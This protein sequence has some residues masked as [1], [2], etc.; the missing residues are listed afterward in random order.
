MLQVSTL[1][2][3][4]H[5]LYESDADHAL[6]SGTNDY[7]GIFDRKIVTDTVRR[8]CF[9]I[10]SEND[11]IREHPEIIEIVGS[12]TGKVNLVDFLKTEVWIIDSSGK[13]H[14]CYSFFKHIQYT[15]YSLSSS[16]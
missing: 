12:I 10:F 3:H 4:T 9:E 16:D 14:M 8:H 7:T 13:D 2:I 1:N 11:G 5:G 15:L 6:S